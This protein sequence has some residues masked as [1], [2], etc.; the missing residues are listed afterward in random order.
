MLCRKMLSRWEFSKPTG[1]VVMTQTGRLMLLLLK[2]MGPEVPNRSTFF[3]WRWDFCS[4]LHLNSSRDLRHHYCHLCETL[5]CLLT[6]F[7]PF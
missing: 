6:P 3:A 5:Q 7:C 2:L 1:F 4:F